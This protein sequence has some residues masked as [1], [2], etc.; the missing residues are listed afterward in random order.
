MEVFRNFMHLSEDFRYAALTIGK[1]IISEVLWFLFS[2]SFI[3][4]HSSPQVFLPDEKK[5]ILPGKMGGRAGGKKYIVHNI[6]FKFAV[7]SYGL[8]GGS[9]W[10]ASK[11]FFSFPSFSFSFF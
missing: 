8:F 11:V 2:F 5:T 4:P 7:D 10:A 6:L 1:I 3:I 9:T